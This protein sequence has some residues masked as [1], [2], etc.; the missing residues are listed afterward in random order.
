MDHMV[1][2][3]RVGLF[4]ATILLAGIVA[5]LVG[6]PLLGRLFGRNLPW[7]VRTF[8]PIIS[9]CWIA[10]IWNVKP[11]NDGAIFGVMA[12]IGICSF[13]LL[14][15]GLEL[16]AECTRN[17]EA[18][19]GFLWFNVNLV[20]FAWVLIM[21]AL[22]AGPNANPPS[23]MTQALIFHSSTIAA[24]AVLFIVAFRGQQKRRAKDIAKLHEA[25]D[26]DDA[27]PGQH[28]VQVFIPEK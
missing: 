5:A 16:G 13:L 12:I 6:A 4:D 8:L 10:Q 21:D 19:C 3:S 14:P 22:R 17:A 25:Q 20:A 7:A 2:P 28:N 15:L 9:A 23:N 26:D 18:S 27:H 11:H 1:I 24:T